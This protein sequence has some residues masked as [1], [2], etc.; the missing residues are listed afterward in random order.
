MYGKFLYD[1]SVIYGIYDILSSILILTGMPNMHVKMFHKVDRRMLSYW[2]FTYGVIR[3]F[4][5]LHV[6]SYFIEA[7][8]LLVEFYYN[9]LKTSGIVS[10]LLCFITLISINYGYTDTYA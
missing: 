4:T 10:L 5:T 3:I 9:N 6:G 2:V 7:T 8:A 1:F